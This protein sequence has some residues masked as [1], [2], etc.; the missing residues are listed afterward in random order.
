[1]VGACGAHVS[2]TKYF[3]KIVVIW[4]CRLVNDVRGAG[5]KERPLSS[6]V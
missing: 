4:C 3:C 1:M 5:E 6:T 2:E